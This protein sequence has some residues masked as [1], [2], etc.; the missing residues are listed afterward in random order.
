MSS[1]MRERGGVSMHPPP[2]RAFEVTAPRVTVKTHLCLRQ[3]VHRGALTGQ[4]PAIEGH[5]VPH[6]TKY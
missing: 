3:Y 6:L 5:A 4:T 2:S 1:T